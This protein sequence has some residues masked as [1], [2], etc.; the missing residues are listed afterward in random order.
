MACVLYDWVY[1]LF[2]CAILDDNSLLKDCGVHSGDLII[3]EKLRGPGSNA[4]TQRAAGMI[5]QLKCDW[6]L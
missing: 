3:V 6:L 5:T 4:P 1:W 2:L